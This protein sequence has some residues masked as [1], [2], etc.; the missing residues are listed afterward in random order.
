MFCELLCIHFYVQSSFLKVVLYCRVFTYKRQYKRKIEV[1]LN[2]FDH[3]EIHVPHNLVFNF[4]PN[5]D[6]QGGRKSTQQ[7]SLH[8]KHMTLQTFLFGNPRY[9]FQKLYQLI[10]GSA[11]THDPKF[12]R[13]TIPFSPPA[14]IEKCRHINFN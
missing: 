13:A 1:V 14:Q 11:M 2:S 4:P 7:T 9:S 5:F 12:M 10:R 8:N 6:I 3:N